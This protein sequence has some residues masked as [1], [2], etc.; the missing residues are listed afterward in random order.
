MSEQDAG[1]ARRTP[2]VDPRLLKHASASRGFFVAIA[3]ISVGQTAVIVVFAWL[4]TRAIVGAIDGMPAAELGATLGALALVVAVRA[5]LVWAREAVASRAAAKVEAQLRMHLVDA[6][7]ALGPRWLATRNTAQLAVTAGRGLAALDPYFGR[8]L[9]QLVQTVIATPV[10]LL[11]MWWQDWIAGLTVLLTLP[12]I[13]VFMVLIGMATRGVQQR[14]WRTLQPARDP[15]RRHGAGPVD[16][17]GVRA[18]A[19]GRGIHPV[20]HRALPR[21][22][23]EGAAGLVP[24]R[25]RP[26]VPREHLGGDHRRLDRLP[27]AR[28][29]A[30]PFGGAVRPAARAGGLPAAAPGRGAVPR[31]RRGCGRDRGRVRRARCGASS[32]SRGTGRRPGPRARCGMATPSCA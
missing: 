31:R 11:V 28:R 3:A 9:P 5:V 29:V 20:R 1:A 25:V 19:P 32:C 16:A 8:Y 15:V 23:D 10:I 24:L 13:P 30:R 21:R 14:Q 7:G 18:S 12:L 4:L 6:V 26:G 17:Q 2:P 22:D 27:A